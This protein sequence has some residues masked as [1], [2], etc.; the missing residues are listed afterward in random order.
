MDLKRESV[1]ANTFIKDWWPEFEMHCKFRGTE[2]GC[3]H[4][5]AFVP[6]HTVASMPARNLYPNWWSYGE[7]KLAG[8]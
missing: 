6:V 2:Y 8:D 4:A 1:L 5:E 7:L 3:H